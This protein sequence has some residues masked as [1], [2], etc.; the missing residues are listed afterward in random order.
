MPATITFTDVV[1]AVHVAAVVVGFGSIFVYPVLLPWARRAHPE[2]LPALHAAQARISQLVISPGMVIV[3]AA[4]V[5]LA[6]KLD[7][8]SEVWVSVP[9]VILI[10]IGG[11]GGAFIAPNEKRLSELAKAGPATPEYAVLANRVMTAQYLAMALVLVAVF[12]MV[13]KP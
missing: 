4:G 3:F 9:L 6:S 12:F 7:V 11:L 2:A 5:Y 13:V 10:V 8:W 1:L